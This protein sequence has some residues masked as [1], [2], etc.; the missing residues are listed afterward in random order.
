M[1]K[2]KTVDEYEIQGLYNDEWEMVTTEETR[3]NAKN[4]KRCYQENE[5]RTI[6]RIVK[7]RIKIKEQES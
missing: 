2:R 4:Q 1:Y 3:I 6:F 7:K 5:P